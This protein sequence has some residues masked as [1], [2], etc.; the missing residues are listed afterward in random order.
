MGRYSVVYQ[1]WGECWDCRCTLSSST[2]KGFALLTL[3]FVVW[4]RKSNSKA[5]VPGCAFLEWQCYLVLS[6]C[7]GSPRQPPALTACPAAGFIWGHRGVVELPWVHTVRAW[8]PLQVSREVLLW[9][10]VLRLTSEP[11]WSFYWWKH[12]QLWQKL[13]EKIRP[14]LLPP[15]GWGERRAAPSWACPVQPCCRAVWEWQMPSSGTEQPFPL[16]HF[17]YG[18]RKLSTFKGK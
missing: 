11:L 14:V 2:N 12:F 4:E 6:C 10:K 1:R 16:W 13:W 15:W 7:K 3:S 8:V 18:K 17:A 9:H 5:D